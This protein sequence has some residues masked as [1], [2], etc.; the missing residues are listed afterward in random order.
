MKKTFKI[1]SLSILA[2]LGVSL[3]AMFMPVSPK[4]VSSSTVPAS[5]KYV[6]MNT[7]NLGSIL[8]N[9]INQQVNILES[10]DADITGTDNK[11]TLSV[12]VKVKNIPITAV[13]KA[14]LAATNESLTVNIKSVRL[15][16]LPIPKAIIFSVLEKY[17]IP[18][19]DTIVLKRQEGFAIQDNCLGVRFSFLKTEKGDEDAAKQALETL[20]KHK[21]E[22]YKNYEEYIG[23]ENKDSLDKL[24]NYI[25]EYKNSENTLQYKQIIKIRLLKH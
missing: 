11:G 20:Y 22:I 18:A 16:Y 13:A 12:Y 4:K 8:K 24:Y 3:G 15:G 5:N 23:K 2:A 10:I 19:T 7:S 9:N 17:S 6:F 25:K 1:V 14:N 21:E